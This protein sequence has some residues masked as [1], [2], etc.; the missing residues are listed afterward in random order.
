MRAKSL[1]PDVGKVPRNE[2]DEEY[3]QKSDQLFADE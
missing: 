3:T 1:P 2:A